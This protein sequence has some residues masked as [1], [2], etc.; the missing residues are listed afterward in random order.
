[1]LTVAASQPQ[2]APKY[3][4]VSD[5]LLTHLISDLPTGILLCDIEGTFL[6]ANNFLADLLGY[7]VDELLKLSYWELTPQK[8]QEKELLQLAALKHT[9]RYGPYEKEYIHCCGDLIPIRLN[10]V[11][12]EIKGQ[13]FIWSVIES[14]SS[15]T[16]RHASDETQKSY[17]IHTEKMSAL[18]QLVAGVAHEINNPIS[19]Y[20]GLKY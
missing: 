6:Y 18:H 9:R 3:P 17:A 8:Y 5:E 2:V 10:G 12:V 13:T 11:L 20:S 1:M 19:N 14:T 15:E 4:G 16:A 7:Q